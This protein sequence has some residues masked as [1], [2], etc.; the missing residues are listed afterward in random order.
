MA[1]IAYLADDE[2][3]DQDLV[4]RMRARRAGGRLGHL[5]RLLLRS[6][7]VAEG[8]GPLMGRIRQDLDLAPHWREL[9]MCA[10]AV[11]NGAADE[12]FH[13]APLLREAGATQAQ[14][15]ALQSLADDADAA[16]S[17][18]AFDEVH[19]AVLRLVVESTTQVTVSDA[20]FANARQH[21]GSDR[22]MF[23][24]VAVTAAYNMVSRI[25]VAFE[26]TPEA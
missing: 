19:R 18:P 15:T 4:K 8:W 7:P 26:V 16:L 11:L 17:S 14:L 20:T 1:R 9:A 6:P 10:V 21:L 23:E 24:L 12:W 5:D 2:L 3:G 22:E 13:H 25:L